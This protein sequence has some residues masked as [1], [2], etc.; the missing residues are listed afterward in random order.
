MIL[1][2]LRKAR[3]IRCFNDPT[4]G[5]RISG[6]TA[7]PSAVVSAAFSEFEDA[8]AVIAIVLT[9]AVLANDASYGKEQGSSAAVIGDPTE[10]CL[11]VATDK[12]DIWKPK[13]EKRSPMAGQVPFDPVRKRM[14]PS[15]S[16][17]R[18]AAAFTPKGPR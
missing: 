1:T 3:R 10:G 2:L 9:N 4:A 14:A 15:T 8:T 17:M 6:G 16:R 18:E 7:Y 13:L 12:A 11:L 5:S